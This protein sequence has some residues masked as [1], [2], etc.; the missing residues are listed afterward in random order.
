LTDQAQHT[1]VLLGTFQL[2][3]Y[4]DTY[5]ESAIIQHSFRSNLLPSTVGP[6]LGNLP[7][8]SSLQHAQPN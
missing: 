7:W 6:A 4:S 8:T 5:T 3:A 1:P 2:T